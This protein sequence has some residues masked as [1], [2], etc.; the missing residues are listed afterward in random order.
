[1]DKETKK[2]KGNL[3]RKLPELE[4]VTKQIIAMTRQQSVIFRLSQM[5]LRIES[6]H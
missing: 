1:M 2:I 5:Q 6:K 3:K 4:N